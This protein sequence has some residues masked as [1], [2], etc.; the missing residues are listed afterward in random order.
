[1]SDT[2]KMQALHQRSVSGKKL[3]GE[4]SIALQNWYDALDREENS[5]INNSQPFQ[6]VE[7]LRRNL[8]QITEQTTEVSREVKIL[9]SQNEE[10]RQENRALKKSLKVRLLE[11]VA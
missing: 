4:E 11:K 2:K 3:T 10:I 5:L 8:E 9:I 6:N 1:M 7:E